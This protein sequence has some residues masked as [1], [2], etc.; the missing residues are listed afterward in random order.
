MANNWKDIVTEKRQ[1]QLA[2]IPP[3]WLIPSESLPPASQLDV[4]SYAESCGLL[5]DNDKIITS[6]NID[7]L[8]SNLASGHWSSVEVTTSFYKRAIIAHQLVRSFSVIVIHCS[9]TL[10]QTNCLTEIF[11]DK[12]LALA[13]E[14]DQYLKTHG[15]PVGP[16]HGLPVSLKDQINI[17]DIESCM[18]RRFLLTAVFIELTI[19]IDEATSPGLVCTPR[20]IPY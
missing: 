3:E 20:R 15:K 19:E 10:D 6:T 17:K 8:L 4:S 7:E 5:S 12:A 11:V 9:Q 14:L 16:L 18:G 13:E 1:R 2:A